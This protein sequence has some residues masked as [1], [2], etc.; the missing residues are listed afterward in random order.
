[1]S[2]ESEP[3]GMPSTT[4]HGFQS[5]SRLAAELQL[6]IMTYVLAEE[7]PVQLF[8]GRAWE[9]CPVKGTLDSILRIRNRALVQYALEACESFLVFGLVLGHTDYSRLQEQHVCPSIQLPVF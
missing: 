4:P 2:P 6:R 7:E 1:M 5:W 3:T 9:R 8:V